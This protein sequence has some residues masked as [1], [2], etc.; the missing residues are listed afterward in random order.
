MC[1]F[2]KLKKV[3]KYGMTITWYNISKRMKLIKKLKYNHDGNNYVGL[4]QLLK[5]V[6]DVAF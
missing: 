6:A 3:Y 1:R 2:L 4:Q 5:S